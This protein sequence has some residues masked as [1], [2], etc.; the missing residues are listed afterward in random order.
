MWHIYALLQSIYIIS[1]FGILS[2]LVIE[3]T[4]ERAG[5]FRREM[6][7]SETESI[8][9]VVVCTAPHLRFY[10]SALL[11]LTSGVFSVAG[12]AGR[13]G[14]KRAPAAARCLL[15]SSWAKYA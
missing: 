1:L 5:G 4:T 2:L 6:R 14:S 7:T 10:G 11:A 3:R 13:K 12:A 15:P 8:S 9:C